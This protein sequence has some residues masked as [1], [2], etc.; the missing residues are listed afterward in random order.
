MLHKRLDIGRDV[1]SDV[2]HR[3]LFTGAASVK[4]LQD[5]AER[6]ETVTVRLND[7]H[8]LERQRRPLTVPHDRIITYLVTPSPEGAKVGPLRHATVRMA[9]V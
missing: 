1:L 2:C 7:D 9:D 5:R 8:D 6:V 4:A 3:F